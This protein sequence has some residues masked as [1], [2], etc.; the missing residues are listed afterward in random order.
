MFK[1]P[2]KYLKPLDYFFMLRP[3]LFFPIWIMTLAGYSGFYI[4]SGSKKWL[5]FSTDWITVLNFLLI[6]LIS[7]G[8]FI[9]N[10]LQDIESDKDNKKLFL[11]SESF[12]QKKHAQTIAFTIISISIVFF[13]VENFYLFIINFFYVLFGGYLYNYKPF[14]WK[15]LPFLGVFVNL[16]EGL[17]LFLS[18][19]LI[20]GYGQW[21][22][23]I[24]VIPYLCAWGAVMFLTTIP[25]VKRDS[26]HNK[27]TFAVRFGRNRT[28]WTAT[29]WVLIGFIVGIINKDYLVTYSIVLSLPLFTIM[30]FKPTHEW[31]FA[32][33]RYPMLFIALLLC[34]EF[35]LFFIV[36]LVNYFFSKAYYVSRFELNYPTFRVKEKRS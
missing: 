21:Q 15:D 18:G 16:I 9:L 3:T 28:I 12:I 26:L 11:I 4:C 19:W 1:I 32:S 33:I 34:V 22:A 36:L 29:I 10:Q 27:I 2:A 25:D 24:Y 8:V 35:P 7:G 5:T 30:L 23:F 17:F 14:C 20:A 13:F 31:I 6:T